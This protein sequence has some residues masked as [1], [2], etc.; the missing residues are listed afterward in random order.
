MLFL[1]KNINIMELITLK[2]YNTEVEAELI[3]AY[4][5]IN[6]VEA[7]VFGNILANTYNVFNITSGGVQLKISV[8]DYNKATDL[9]AQ[10]YEN[11]KES[12]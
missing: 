5:E 4:L 6:G 10:F 12:D 2:T 1:T 7:F 3:K 8:D 9:L 11:Q